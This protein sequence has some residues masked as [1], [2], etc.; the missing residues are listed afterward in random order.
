MGNSLALHSSAGAGR[1]PA[2]PLARRG[3]F[4]PSSLLATKR[5]Q[6][7]RLKINA[8]RDI[9]SEF[10][11]LSLGDKNLRIAAVDTPRRGASADAGIPG[12]AGEPKR[13]GAHQLIRTSHPAPALLPALSD[14]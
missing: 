1:A 14:L 7:R 13:I 12:Q 6:D 4:P 2:V 10:S 9:G 3:P 5:G 8:D 11:V